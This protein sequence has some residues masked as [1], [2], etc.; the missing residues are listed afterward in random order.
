MGQESPVEVH[1]AQKPTELACS[2]WRVAVP[3]IGHSF[4]QR[5]GTLGRHLVTEEGDLGCS[6][7]ALCHID[8]DPIPLKLVEE[9]P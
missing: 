7:D 4:I 3:E 5:L 8:V 1:H 2:L 6:K 9:C